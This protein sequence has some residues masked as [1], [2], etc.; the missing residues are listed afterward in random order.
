MTTKPSSDFTPELITLDKDHL[1]LPGNIYFI[2]H[3]YW[4]LD[5]NI[6]GIL[7]LGR[8]EHLGDGQIRKSNSYTIIR[9]KSWM[10]KNSSFAPIKKVTA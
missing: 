7:I 2:Q 10:L 6:F 1:F 3:S 9:S 4:Y 8:G 5:F